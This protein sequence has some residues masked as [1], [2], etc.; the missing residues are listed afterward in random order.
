MA[1]HTRVSSRSDTP[2]RRRWLA[3]AAVSSAL[4]LA[5]GA[6][7]YVRIGS[8]NGPVRHHEPPTAAGKRAR[9]LGF[10]AASP[11][12][13]WATWY[14]TVNGGVTWTQAPAPDGGFVTDAGGALWL[15][16]SPTS[17]R[18]L[19]SSDNGQKW[20]RM[21]LPPAV[22]GDALNV[23]GALSTGAV[24]LVADAPSSAT[25]AAVTVLT[26]GDGGA[27]WSTLA[28]ASFRGK[29]G[30]NVPVAAAVAGN[31]VWLGSGSD[32]VPQRISSTGKVST[33]AAPPGATGIAAITAASGSSSWAT[34]V[35]TGCRAGKA[36][37]SSAQSL[38]ATSNAGSSWSPLALAATG[39]A[40]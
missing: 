7:A 25:S 3:R 9:L 20:V 35:A 4:L 39:S 23:P 1:Q 28:R 11:P 8:G 15:V 34:G 16:S 18:L 33:L 22:T 24:V 37:C 6:S 30:A 2:G 19:R 14:S 32:P 31:A 5:G 17:R 13:S 10:T 40:G 38:F 29:V 36:S 12:S 27:T 21:S 26:T